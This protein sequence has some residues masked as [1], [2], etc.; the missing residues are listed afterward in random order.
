MLAIIAAG[1]TFGIVF[2]SVWELGQPWIQWGT[3]QSPPFA[4]IGDTVSI[5]LPQRFTDTTSRT[6][7]A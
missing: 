1:L 6:P 5:R 7:Y 2:W 3:I 4:G